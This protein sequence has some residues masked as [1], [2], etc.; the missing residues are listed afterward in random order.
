MSLQGTVCNLKNVFLCCI[1]VG[2][3]ASQPLICCLITYTLVACSTDMEE[4]ATLLMAEGPLGL[5]DRNWFSELYMWC[6]ILITH[7]GECQMH[8]HDWATFI[9]QPD[10]LLLS[11][12][13]LLPFATATCLAF[14]MTYCGVQ[15]SKTT[16]ENA[17]VEHFSIFNIVYFVVLTSY[18]FFVFNQVVFLI[19]NNNLF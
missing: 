13:P 9:I 1:Y 8:V 3:I 16:S 4:A 5:W 7:S 15:K 19:V 12:F 6:L 10:E 17:C 18:I 11:F 2:V 14:K